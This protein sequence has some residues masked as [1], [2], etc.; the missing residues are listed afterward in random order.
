MHLDQPSRKHWYY[1]LKR[2]Y[3]QEE[4]IRKRME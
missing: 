1:R 3:E 2:E 4:E